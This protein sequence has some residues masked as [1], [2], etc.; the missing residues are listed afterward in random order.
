LT[1]GIKTVAGAL[2]KIK[3]TALS[4]Y[5][6]SNKDVLRS[7]GNDSSEVLALGDDAEHSKHEL[8]PAKP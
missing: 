1:S 4:V 3:A 8:L 2:R 6:A 5:D 7:P